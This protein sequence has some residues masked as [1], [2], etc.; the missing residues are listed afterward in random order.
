MEFLIFHFR[1]YFSFLF[2]ELSPKLSGFVHVTP[3]AGGDRRQ[4]ETEK[5]ARGCQETG[6]DRECLEPAEDRWSQEVPG[7]ARE[8]QGQPG[9]ARSSQE[10]PGGD[11]RQGETGGDRRQEE[12]E[13]A[14]GAREC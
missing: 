4:V 1:T 12:T 13:G 8:R 5:G 11:R 9:S 14:R 2:F 7:G 3:P 10:E 6:G